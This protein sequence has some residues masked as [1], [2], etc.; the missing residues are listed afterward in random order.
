M[1][2]QFGGTNFFASVLGNFDK[3][4]ICRPLDNIVEIPVLRSQL[5]VRLA[6]PLL[7]APLNA[8]Y[9]SPA[10]ASNKPLA[11]K[12]CKDPLVYK[13]VSETWPSYRPRSAEK[14]E[15]PLRL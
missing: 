10:P 3:I 4:A 13:L 15:V 9:A 14:P 12:G 1:V 2:Y 6:L 8:M 5:A 11:I 7:L